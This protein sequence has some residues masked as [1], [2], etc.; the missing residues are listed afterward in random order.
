[1]TEHTGL[2]NSRRKKVLQNNLLQ[3]AITVMCVAYC[4]LTSE[5][6]SSGSHWQLSNDRSSLIKQWTA[7]SLHFISVVKSAEIV[8]MVSTNP[9]QPNF[10][11]TF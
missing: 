7:G 1:M 2:T 8:S 11:D 9:N 5:I 10:Q 6:R 4:V 3:C